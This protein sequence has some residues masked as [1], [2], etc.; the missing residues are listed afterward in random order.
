MRASAPRAGAHRAHREHC[1]HLFCAP[2]DQAPV[3]CPRAP[4]GAPTPAWRADRPPMRRAAPSPLGHPRMRC[5]RAHAA[6][7][8]AQRM[9][10]IA[11][12]FAARFAH[13][14]RASACAAHAQRA[15][16]PRARAWRSGGCAE[17]T[18]CNA[19]IRR[20]SGAAHVLTSQA[21][22]VAE[23]RAAWLWPR[24]FFRALRRRRAPH[25]SRMGGTC[26]LT[27]PHPDCHVA[28]TRSAS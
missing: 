4:P 15:R 19:R 21:H 7:A 13:A 20:R 10:S 16:S 23:C 28:T 26:D 12:M 5:A 18:G 2:S 24:F 1:A 25:C 14:A 27:S 3:T 6:C 22:R 17:R 8:L 9:H 11:C